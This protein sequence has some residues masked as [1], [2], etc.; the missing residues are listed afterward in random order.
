LAQERHQVGL[1]FLFELEPLYKIEELDRIF[2][3]QAAAVRKS[4][5]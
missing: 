5:R 3:R 1:F 2:Q 4:C